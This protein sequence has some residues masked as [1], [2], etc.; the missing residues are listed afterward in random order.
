MAQNLKTFPL[1]FLLGLTLLSFFLY[2]EEGYASEKLNVFVSIPPQAYF[3]E[4]IGRDLVSVEVLIGPG[5]SPE[6]F[7]PSPRLM[8]R[9][10]EA[11]LFIRVGV[12]FEI[13]LLEKIGRIM[14]ALKMIDCRDG[15]ELLPISEVQIGYSHGGHFH[16]NLDPHIWLDPVRA[17]TMALT[18]AEALSEA[19]PLH[20]TDYQSNL[21]LLLDDLKVFHE[22]ITTMLADCSGKRFYVFH[23]SFGY[24][25]ARYNLKQTAV[26]VGGREPG[27]REMVE[28]IETARRDSIVAIII[29]PQF[30]SKTAASVADQIGCGLVTIDPLSR[31]Y[32]LNLYEIARKVKQAIGCYSPMTDKLI[33]RMSQ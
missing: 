6:A 5:Q 33:L 9:L 3:V 23:P 20:S 19:D 8:G 16:D 27:A 29:Q 32:L 13:T 11:D 28:L 14:P 25:A 24:F 30:S 1:T 18:I 10:S 15:I 22:K 4:R 31:D 2:I 17:Q 7:D 26:E 12:P 21:Y